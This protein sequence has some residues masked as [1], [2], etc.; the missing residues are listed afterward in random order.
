[1]FSGIVET[2][3]TLSRIEDRD[4]GARLFVEADAGLIGE[5]ELGESVAVNGCCLT[6]TSTSQ[7]TV[8]FDVLAET[9]RLTNIGT[10]GV[11]GTVNLERSLRVGDRVSGHFVQGHVDHTTQITSFVKNG[12]DWR[13]EV[14]LPVEGRALVALK[15]S[16][17]VDGI[18]LTIAEVN[19]GSFV[20]WII[21]HT[22][23]ITRLRQLQAG[24]PVNLEYDL[25]ARYTKRIHEV[26]SA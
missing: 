6:V 18:S 26:E 23:E 19:E 15:G 10:V 3:G 11:G 13:L 16:I 24:D 9:L 25:L 14:E 8:T 12:G 4:D 20:L 7:K 2:T 17:C 1:M 22:R 5:L 21:P